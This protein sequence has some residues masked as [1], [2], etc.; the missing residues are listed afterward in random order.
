VGKSR[1]A[2]REYS[3]PPHAAAMMGDFVL[4]ALAKAV[5][6]KPRLLASSCAGTLAIQSDSEVS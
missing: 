5:S 1:A 3:V 6:G 2:L 4:R